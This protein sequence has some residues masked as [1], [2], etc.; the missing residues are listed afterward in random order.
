M[1]F[2]NAKWNI[3]KKS[4]L[5]VNKNEFLKILKGCGNL[6]GKCGKTRR[7]CQA[8]RRRHQRFPARRRR[9]QT[10]APPPYDS[11][12]ELGRWLTAG[13]T[14]PVHICPSFR[15]FAQVAIEN[16]INVWFT[17]KVYPEVTQAALNSLV[18]LLQ[19]FCTS[20]ARKFHFIWYF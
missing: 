14:V 9:R 20:Y 7:R 19:C 3:R 13:W 4:N 6:R 11:H 10:R 8:R 1:C 17:F 2:F 12:V 15:L 16:F 5:F 18:D